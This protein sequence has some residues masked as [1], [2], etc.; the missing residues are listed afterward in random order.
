ML[1]YKDMEEKIS[2]DAEGDEILILISGMPTMKCIKENLINS[3]DYFKVLICNCNFKEGISGCINFSLNEWK[4]EYYAFFCW[5]SSGVDLLKV[6]NTRCLV[7]FIVIAN[8]FQLKS[9]LLEK[10]NIYASQISILD[11]TVQSY[12]TPYWSYRFIPFKTMTT[13]ILSNQSPQNNNSLIKCILAWLDEKTFKDR[14]E[15]ESCEEFHLVRDFLKTLSSWL[16]NNLQELVGILEKYPYASQ[17]LDIVPL[18]SNMK[19]TCYCTRF[20]PQ[21]LFKYS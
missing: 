20:T 8:Y 21:I 6:I 16:P 5:I 4:E 2:V 13:M 15:L 11:T 1:F 18:L 7:F 10:L 19:A 14:R 9:E 17:V 12:L 3:S